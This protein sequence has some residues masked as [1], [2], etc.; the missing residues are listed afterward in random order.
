MARIVEILVG[1]SAIAGI[2][3]FLG[4][5]YAVRRTLRG[6]GRKPQAPPPRTDIERREL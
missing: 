1:V 6:L 2:A 4:L 5:R 3:S